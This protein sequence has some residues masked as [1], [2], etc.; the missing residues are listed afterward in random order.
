MNTNTFE[1]TNFQYQKVPWANNPKTEAA[2]TCIYDSHVCEN[3]TTCSRTLNE[4]ILCVYMNEYVCSVEG[5]R[6]RKQG[7]FWGVCQS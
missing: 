7:I 4:H 3:H 5:A 6:E 2:C 1:Y